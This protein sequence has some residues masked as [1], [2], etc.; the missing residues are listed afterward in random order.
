MC[1]R[2]SA[3]LRQA[4]LNIVRNATEALRAC[5]GGLLAVSAE[6]VDDEVRLNFADDGPGIDG[7]VATKIFDPFFSTKKSG[8]GLGLPLTHQVI[9]EHGGR[10]ECRSTPGEGTTF[11]IWLPVAGPEETRSS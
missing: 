1:I 4:L 5:G 9:S 8:S 6:A 7:D 3:Q 2:D 11:S 10:I